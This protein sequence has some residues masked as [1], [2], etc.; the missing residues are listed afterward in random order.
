[1]SRFDQKPNAP[2]GK[3]EDGE[4][5]QT[6]EEA[7]AY[8]Q[9]TLEEA[10]KQPGADPRKEIRSKRVWVLNPPRERQIHSEVW[11][12]LDDRGPERGAEEIAEW[13]HDGDLTREEAEK[14]I[15]SWDPDPMEAFTRWMDDL[16]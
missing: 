6:E 8:Q 16:E 1:M 4:I 11:E 13:V 10:R 14:A 12:E 3:G 7:N 2:Y 5:F 15:L 9:R